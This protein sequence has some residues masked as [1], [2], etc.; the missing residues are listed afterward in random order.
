MVAFTRWTFLPNRALR[1]PT[2]SL[3]LTTNTR[4]PYWNLV[5]SFGI[6]VLSSRVIAIILN[7]LSVSGSIGLMNSASLRSSIAESSFILYTA[8][9]SLPR[10]NSMVSAV[11]LCLRKSMISSAADL[12]G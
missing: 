8:I 9:C 7:C 4:S 12:S 6:I 5:P 11:E 1:V 3:L 2:A 10:A